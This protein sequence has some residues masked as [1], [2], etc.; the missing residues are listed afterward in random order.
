MCVLGLQLQKGF[1]LYQGIYKQLSH[2]EGRKDKPTKHL[3]GTEGGGKEGRP[4]LSKVVKGVTKQA[5]AL[6]LLNYL[7]SGRGG[8]KSYEKERG[9]NICG[10]YK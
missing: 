8:E 10:S 6:P 5:Y 2:D 1:L 3:R 9:G 7:Q 4:H